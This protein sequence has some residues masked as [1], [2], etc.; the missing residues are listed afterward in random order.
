MG[1][2]TNQMAEGIGQVESIKRRKREIEDDSSQLNDYF[3]F[4]EDQIGDLDNMASK[5]RT[6]RSLCEEKKHVLTI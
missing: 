2:G 5:F 1:I 3:A 4:S 6:G